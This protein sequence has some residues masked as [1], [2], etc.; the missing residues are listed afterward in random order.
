M[1]CIMIDAYAQESGA[2]RCVQVWQGI[3]DAKLE[4]DIPLEQDAFALPST[5]HLSAVAL[6]HC[7]DF[8]N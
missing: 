4:P 6:S 1:D 5:A 3:S 8:S 2:C 7:T